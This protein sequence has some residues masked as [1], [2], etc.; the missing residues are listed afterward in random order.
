LL[1][2]PIKDPGIECGHA[3]SIFRRH[4]KVNNRIHFFTSDL[5]ALPAARA[6]VFSDFHLI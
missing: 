4:F 3:L 1:C 5:L 6:G 2:L